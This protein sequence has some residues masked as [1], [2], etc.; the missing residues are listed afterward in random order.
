MPHPFRVIGF[1]TPKKINKELKTRAVRLVMGIGVS[2]VHNAPVQAVARQVGGGQGP[3]RRCVAQ[4]AVDSGTGPGVTTGESEE[5][6][7]LKT[8]NLRLREDVVRSRRA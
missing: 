3:V 5:S 1:R 6:K 7:R 2:S 4:A 8:E